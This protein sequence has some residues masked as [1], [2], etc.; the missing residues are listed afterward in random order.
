VVALDSYC[1]QRILQ[2]HDPGFDPE[3][4]RPTLDKA[5]QLGLGT[6][7]LSEVDILE[8]DE[9]WEPQPKKGGHRR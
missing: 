3:V 2:L 9:T 8:I 6:S 4:I 7:D 1:A 5:E